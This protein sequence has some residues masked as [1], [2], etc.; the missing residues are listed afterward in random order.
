MEASFKIIMNELIDDKNIIY[1]NIV[2]T[3]K[4]DRIKLRSILDNIQLLFL[5]SHMIL[6]P[7]KLC[8][9]EG[10]WKTVIH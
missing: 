9:Q 6:R 10:I 1:W 2:Q 3:E 7:I 4:F 8:D 5:D